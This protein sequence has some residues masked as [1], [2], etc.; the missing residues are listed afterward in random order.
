ML[1]FH[2]VEMNNTN[3][4]SPLNLLV[5]SKPLLSIESLIALG[6][7]ENVEV[8]LEW[9]FFLGLSL[10]CLVE[11]LD[12]CLFLVVPEE[13]PFLDASKSD[14]IICSRVYSVTEKIMFKKLYFH[15]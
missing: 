1:R 8:A 14:D 6:M 4:Y 10:L 7:E 15:F 12:L 13:F 9:R 2:E 5:G 11:D 3:F